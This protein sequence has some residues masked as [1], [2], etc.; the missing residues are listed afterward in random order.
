MLLASKIEQG[1]QLHREGCAGDRIPGKTRIHK[2]K[3]A[4]SV[5]RPG[6]GVQGKGQG[7][8]V[9]GETSCTKFMFAMM[10]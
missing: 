2:N 1:E 5:R 9:A 4:I 3:Q 10:V 8:K 6:Q 7:E